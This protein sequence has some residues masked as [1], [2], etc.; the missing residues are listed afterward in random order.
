MRSSINISQYPEL[1][2]DDWSYEMG[3]NE[4]E[5]ESKCST[6][7]QDNNNNGGQGCAVFVLFIIITV[8]AYY[9]I[10]V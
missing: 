10:A 4:F 2:Y 3:I 5:N 6:P 8:I 7:V 1:R 9:L